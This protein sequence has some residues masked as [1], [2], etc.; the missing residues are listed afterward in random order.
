VLP[1][2]ATTAN[3]ELSEELSALKAEAQ[4]WQANTT[5]QLQAQEQ[6]WQQQLAAA[7]AAAQEVQQQLQRRLQQQLCELQQQQQRVQEGQQQCR[8]LQ[9][10]LFDAQ[11]LSKDAQR[12]AQVRRLGPCLF[13][14]PVGRVARGPT[15]LHV[16][17]AACHT[18]C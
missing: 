15:H 16:K 11:L 13:Q 9:Q 10:Q 2:V 4:Q 17:L 1:N 12:K 18:L 3:R 6:Q 14:G 7:T 5:Q 8:E